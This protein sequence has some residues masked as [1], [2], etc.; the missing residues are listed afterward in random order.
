M[1]WCLCKLH[2]IVFP[3][4]Q[5]SNSTCHKFAHTKSEIRKMN[6]WKTLKHIIIF[7]INTNRAQCAS[8]A[9][10][11][12]QA[13]LKAVD[14]IGNWQRLA[15]TVGVSQHICIKQQTCENLSSIGHQT[16][17]SCEIIMKEENT[18]V[19]RS[20]VRLDGWFRDLKF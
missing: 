8:H 17:Q 19:T 7:N 11:T 18:L 14:T 5:V 4:C 20:C 2:Q 13:S 15:F 12:T 10:G 16:C 9:F 6:L 3:P 1:T